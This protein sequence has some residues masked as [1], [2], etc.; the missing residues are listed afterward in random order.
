MDLNIFKNNL[1][2]YAAYYN[3]SSLFDKIKKY[4][5]KAVVFH[6]VCLRGVCLR[7]DEQS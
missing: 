7:S 4:A 5:K 1:E 6:R 3:P 2:K